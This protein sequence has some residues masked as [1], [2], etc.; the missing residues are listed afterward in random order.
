M[1]RGDWQVLSK[2]HFGL[3]AVF[4]VSILALP[5]LVYTGNYII[6]DAPAPQEGLEAPPRPDE[7]LSEGLLFIVLDGGSKSLM[8]DIEYMPNLNEKRRVGTY[9]DVLT[10]PLTMTASCVKEMATGI[11]SRPNEGL[12]NFHPEHPGTPDGWTLASQVDRDGDGI[13]DY[14]VG[15]V[16]D[17]VWGDLYS[18]NEDINFM[19]HRYGHADYYD[20]DI[21][22]FETLNSWL[23]GDVPISNTRPGK[24]YDQ[25]PNIIIAHLSGLDSVGHRYGVKD[26]AEYA[27]KLKW[28]DD[29]FATIFEK[30]PETWTVVVTADHGLTDNGQHGSP[31]PEIREVN[32]FMWGPNI[33]ENY[34]YPEEI[35]QRD[36]ATLPSLLFSLPLPHAVHGKFPIDALDVTDEYKQELNQWNWDATI[37]RNEWMKENGHSYIKDLDKEKIEWSKINYEEIGLRTTDLILSLL[38]FSAILVA[39]NYSGKRFGLSTSLRRHSLAISSSAF[40]F[41]L[42]LSYNRGVLA[43]PYYVIGY[44]LPI[45]C[46][47]TCGLCLFGN[48]KDKPFYRKISF[49]SVVLFVFMLMFTETRISALNIVALVMM[50]VPSIM[51]SDN[52]LQSSKLITRTLAMVLIPIAFL[53]HPRVFYWSMP[54]WIIGISIQHDIVPLLVNTALISCGLAF[55]H[56]HTKISESKEKTYTTF[57]LFLL[58]P[59]IMMMENNLLDW[60]LLSGLLAVLCLSMYRTLTQSDD[61]ME[62][63]TL[64]VLYWLTMSWGGYVGAISMVLFTAFRSLFANELKLLFESQEHFEREL[65]RVLLLMI[66]PIAVW[67]VWWTSIGQI[68]GVLHPR[69]VDPG[70]LYLNGGY[71]GDRFSPSNAWVGFMGGGPIVAMSL[72]WWSMFHKAGFSIKILS[73]FIL[74]RLAILSL[75]LSISPNLPRLVFKLSWDILSLF[76]LLGFSLFVV[77]L[78]Y[79]LQILNKESSVTN[80]R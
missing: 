15:I 13:E 36:F 68:G 74:L 45:A 25:A 52:Q 26:S 28:L 64:A 65:S 55:Y 72:L 35:D 20:G 51:R 17:Y 75:Q 53:S 8:G 43:I 63:A 7:P 23:D 9:F 3:I 12:N 46:V 32:A 50:F 41:S 30:V 27:E 79:I 69:D 10:N 11:P 77:S 71:I 38:M 66:I 1:E 59:F 29:N 58:I 56:H 39:L 22:S 80:T 42:V 73:S 40:V 62:L 33:E 44:M 61:D 24:Q 49:I 14:R 48:G 57:A 16:G 21:E 6:S 37:S 18:E 60:I 70:Y 5:S 34:Y 47:I 78:Q 19:R 54:R 2:S 4:L 76:T 31:D 67:F